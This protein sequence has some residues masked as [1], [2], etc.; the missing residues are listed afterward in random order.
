MALKEDA[1]KIIEEIGGELV[2]KQVY[3]FDDPRKYPADFLEEC[4]HFL[5]DIIGQESAEK[6]FGP[7]YKKYMKAHQ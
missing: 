1:K 5:G 2:A 3:L 6:K 7:L 4:T